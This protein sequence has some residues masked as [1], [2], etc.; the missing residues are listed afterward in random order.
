MVAGVTTNALV[1]NTST[2]VAEVVM[3]ISTSDFLAE[4]SSKIGQTVTAVSLRTSAIL[5]DWSVAS[6][7]GEAGKTLTYAVR[8]TAAILTA[9]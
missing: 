5:A 3:A 9:L 6:G 2:R 7:T 1:T 4:L 8:E